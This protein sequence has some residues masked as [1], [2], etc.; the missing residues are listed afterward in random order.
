MEEDES[1]FIDDIEQ[2]ADL[3]DDTS[4]APVI[5]LVNQMI[6]KREPS[7]TSIFIL[8]GN[9]ETFERELLHIYKNMTATSSKPIRS[10][11]LGKGK[12]RRQ[13]GRGMIPSFP[14]PTPLRGQS[15]AVGANQKSSEVNG[16]NL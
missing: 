15:G 9:S 6:S 10:I 16:E 11:L 14:C 7:D 13:G 2:T 5:R 1:V 12:Q 4:D 3:L 8:F